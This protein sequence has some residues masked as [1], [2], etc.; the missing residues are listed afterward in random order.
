MHKAETADDRADAIR[1]ILDGLLRP[2]K[3][4]PGMYLWD[5]RGS[6]LFDRI[7]RTQDYYLAREETALL[8]RNAGEIAA[9]VGSG[10]SVV[11]LGS[12]ASHKVRVL[13][14]T[15][16]QPRR[17]VAIDI[18]RGFVAAALQRLAQDYPGLQVVPVIADYT[19]PLQLPETLLERPV[20][21]FFA[22]STIGNFAPDKARAFLRRVRD[23]LGPSWL[24]IGTD[25]TE[26]VTRLRRAYA[27][28][29]GLMAALHKNLL[30]H[31]NRLVGTDFDEA[32][33]RHDIRI[34]ADP[35]RVEARLVALRPVCVTVAGREIAIGAGEAIRTDTS[36]K[37]D[38]HIFLALAQDAGWTPIRSWPED[39]SALSLYLLRST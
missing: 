27:E 1:Q 34:A 10:A 13:L 7:C 38:R 23:A 37:Y 16:N 30:L 31:L 24:L 14:E 2:E 29:D 21:G 32:D 17:Y 9:L 36:F 3:T 8:R 25:A 33:F 5:E 28:A 39:G 19:K 22:G 26:D 20:L 15:L 12:G 11:E 6:D 4:F 18:S 35:P